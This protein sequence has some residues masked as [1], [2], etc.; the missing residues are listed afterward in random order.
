LGATYYRLDTTRPL[1][2]ALFDFLRQR[3]QRRRSVQRRR[4]PI[5]A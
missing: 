3:L 1:E 2:L 5:P 4:A